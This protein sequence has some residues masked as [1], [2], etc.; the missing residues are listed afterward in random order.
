MDILRGKEG[1]DLRL[2]KEH[3]LGDDASRLETDRL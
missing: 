2:E 1:G 3:R